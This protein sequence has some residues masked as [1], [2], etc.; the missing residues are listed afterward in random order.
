MSPQL[1]ARP[2]QPALQ[3]A[4]K[5][6]QTAPAQ[7]TLEPVRCGSCDALLFKASPGAVTGTLSIKCRRCGTVNLIRATP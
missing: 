5:P 4:L 7:G 3:G 1:V 2:S 6:P